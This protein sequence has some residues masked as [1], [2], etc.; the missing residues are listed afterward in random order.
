MKPAAHIVQWS[1]WW[2]RSKTTA[3][4]ARIRDWILKKNQ[5][6]RFSGNTPKWYGWSPRPYGAELRLLLI[7]SIC[8][9]GWR[10]VTCCWTGETCSRLRQLVDFCQTAKFATSFYRAVEPWAPFPRGS[11]AKN[12]PARTVRLFYLECKSSKHG[13]SKVCCDRNLLMSSQTLKQINGN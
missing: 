11:R 10:M 8:S 12:R 9:T 7:A 13:I 6:F 2:W 1:I 5:I 3:K 4:I